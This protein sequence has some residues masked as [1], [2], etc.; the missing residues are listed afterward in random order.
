MDN[1]TILDLLNETFRLSLRMALPLLLISMIVGIIIAIFQ[2]ATQINEQTMTFVP[3]LLVL[4]IALVA[5]GG[6]MLRQLQDFFIKICGLI[7]SGG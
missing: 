4:V 7:A 5:V 1:A 3:K 2:A 6:T